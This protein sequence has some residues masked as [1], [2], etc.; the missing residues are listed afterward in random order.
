MVGVGGRVGG[1]AVAGR[2]VNVGTSA[3]D[4]APGGTGIVG[5]AVAVEVGATTTGVTVG[6]TPAGERA[7]DGPPTARQRAIPQMVS[8]YFI[9]ILLTEPTRHVRHGFQ[10]LGV[11]KLVP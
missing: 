7:R 5:T 1:A 11:L 10:A 4:F 9:Y 6:V 3:R 2:G 8:Q